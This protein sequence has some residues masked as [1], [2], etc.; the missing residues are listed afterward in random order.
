MGSR[1]LVARIKLKKKKK[2]R[3]D[4]R[5]K[6]KSCGKAGKPPPAHHLLGEEGGVPCIMD[7]EK[8]GLFKAGKLI[9][10]ESNGTS[11][12]DKLGA[13]DHSPEGCLH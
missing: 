4:T 2:K 5:G 9:E 3:P 12:V 1:K 7:K 11:P 8:P 10:A 6:E 13:A